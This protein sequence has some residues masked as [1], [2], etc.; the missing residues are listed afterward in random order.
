MCAR[1]GTKTGPKARI[2]TALERAAGSAKRP[3]NRIRNRKQAGCLRYSGK[4]AGCLRY[5]WHLILG[6]ILLAS[7]VWGDNATFSLLYTGATAEWVR[8]SSPVLV[9]LDGDGQTLEIV[10]G[11]ESGT[12]YGFDSTAYL[13]WTFSIRNFPGYEWVQTACQSAPAVA[14]LD[15]DGAMEVVVTL[16]SRE[17]WLPSKPGAIFMFRLDRGGQNPTA[18]GGFARLTVDRNPPDN[19]ADGSFP[20]PTV[21]DLNGDGVLEILASSWDELCYALRIDGSPLWDPNYD[22]TDNQEFGFKAGDTI[23][24]TPAVADIDGD[25]MSEVIFG[26]DAH[27]YPWGHHLPYQMRTGGLLVILEAISGLLEFGPQGS[28]KFFIESYHPEGD[29]WYYNPDGPNHVPLVNISQVL[30]SSPVAGDVDADGRW[31]ILHGTGQ[32]F[33]KPTDS[34]HNRV[35]C[36]NGENAT[37]QWATNLG[38]EVFATCA[39]ANV[40]GDPDLEVFARNFNWDAPVLFGLKGR[41]GAVLPGFPAPLKPGNPRSISAVIGDVEGDGQ[42]EIITLSFGRVHVFGANGVEESAFEV[43]NALYTSPAIG[44][45]DGDGQCE[46]VIGAQHGISV[47]RSTGRVGSIVWGQ[48]RRDARNSGVVPPYDAEPILVEPL[49]PIVAGQSVDVRV[50]FCNTGSNVWTPGTVALANQTE[51]IAP[52]VISLPPSTSIPNGGMLDIAF[53]MEVPARPGPLTLAFQLVGPD[54]MCYGKCNTCE[55]VVS[56]EVCGVDRW[57]FYY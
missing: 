37:L 34:Q 24:T 57:Q 11:D 1:T 20:S 8:Y 3:G 31:E 45:I 35:F 29:D 6:A 33:Y 46:L 30:Q 22:L 15:G 43:P 2:T 44:D 48:Y 36:W 41:N 52:S 51:G 50:C 49:G 42:M 12:I 55:V 13:R 18:V 10:V 7:A 23:W 28:G 16:A 32:E 4:K 14:D 5:G 9:D 53:S 39:L 54:S 56:G 26:A 19:I 25:G 21:A 47:Y 27:D 40:D 38:A 17:E